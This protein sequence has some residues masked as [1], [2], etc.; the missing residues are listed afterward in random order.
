MKWFYDLKIGVK[1][2][3]SFTVVALIAGLIGILGIQNIKKIEKADTKL[4]E[5]MTVPLAQLGDVATNFHRMRV[6]LREAILADTPAEA[7]RYAELCATYK[8]EIDKSAQSYEKT[9]ISDRMKDAYAE[10]VQTRQD[11]APVME[12]TLALAAANKDAQAIKRMRDGLPE[13][14]AEQAAIDKMVEMKL[15]DAKA[16]SDNN[17]A[18]AKKAAQTMIILMLAG[19]GTA[20]WLGLFIAKIIGNPLKRLSKVADKLAVGDVNVKVEANTK[21]E[22]GDLSRSMELMVEN[23]QAQATAAQKIADGDLSIEVRAKCSDDVLSNAMTSMIDSL[24]SLVNEARTLSQAAVDGNLSLRGDATKY[25]G[26]YKDIVSGV[27]QTLD[28]VIGPINEAADVL[29]R[30]AGRDMTARV[31]GDY[32]GDLAKIKNTLNQAVD[33]LDEGLQQV[34]VG[35]EQVASASNQI[36]SGSQSLAQGASEQASSL[37]EVSSSL[38]EL[39]SMTKQNTA[40]S[41]EARGMADNA[42]RT[43]EVGASSMTRLS[44]AIDK[45]KASSDETAKIIKT[46]DEIAFQTNLLALNAAVEAARAGDAGKGFAVVAEEVRNLAMQSAAAAKNTSSVIEEAVKNAEGGVEINQ[47]VI[48][49]LDEINTQVEK[50]SEVM[51]EIAAASE[52]QNQGIEQISTAVGQMDQVTQSNAANSEESA[53]AAEELSGQAEEMRTMV[54]SFKLSSKTSVSSGFGGGGKPP[55]VPPAAKA[56]PEKSTVGASVSGKNGKSDNPRN[57]IPFD[58]DDTL[59]DF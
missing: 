45:I 31:N 24:R 13:A 44:E 1:L 33:N 46:I 41:K 59:Q 52:Q 57:L 19:M 21:D 27:N 54:S 36:S 30:V 47:E 34:A 40:N 29:Q 26:G 48:K 11:F 15:K 14:K 23:I 58:N 42:R 7:R 37:Q 53:S 17:S 8:A 28:A 6:N 35:A 4:Y 22:V 55:R 18:T 10:F 25:S 12:Q 39:A 51:S 32:K 5:R 16:T 9:I 2:V 3:I 38:A 56:K 49:N 43:A 50:V 20:I